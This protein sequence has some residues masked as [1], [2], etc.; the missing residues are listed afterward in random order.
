MTITKDCEGNELHAGD[1]VENIY[2]KGLPFRFYTYVG[3]LSMEEFRGKVMALFFNNE[4]PEEELHT[5]DRDRY[6]KVLAM[7][8]V[9]R[10]KTL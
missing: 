2:Q 6:G 5:Y 1:V 8:L 4:K 7:R 3:K 9:A 10:K